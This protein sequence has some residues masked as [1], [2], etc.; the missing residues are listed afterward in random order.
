MNI[1]CFSVCF[2]GELEVNGGRHHLVS[3]IDA[4]GDSSKSRVF[5]GQQDHWHLFI[6]SIGTDLTSRINFTG[7]EKAGI[8][9]S[10]MFRLL[11]LPI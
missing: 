8:C 2:R 6:Q 10:I 11:D 3:A 7:S 4:N 5:R 9:K 1:Q